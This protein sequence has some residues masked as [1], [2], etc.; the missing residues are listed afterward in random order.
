LPSDQVLL[1]EHYR[2]ISLEYHPEKWEGSD[3]YTS[4]DVLDFA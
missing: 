2:S 4:C 3:Y 1:E